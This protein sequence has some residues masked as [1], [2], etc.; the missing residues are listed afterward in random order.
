MKRS[1]ILFMLLLA[2]PVLAAAQN[3]NTQ[4][5]SNESDPPSNRSTAVRDRVVGPTRAANHAERQKSLGEDKTDPPSTSARELGG[6]AN[7][8][9]SAPQWGNTAVVIRSAPNERTMPVETATTDKPAVTEQTKKPPTKLVQKTSFTTGTPNATLLNRVGSPGSLAAPGPAP[10]VVY[11]VGVGDVLDIRLSNLP[12]KESTLFTVLKNGVLEYPLLSAPI[13]I[14]GMT[15]DEVARVL[16]NE[17]KVL[18][19]ARVSVSVRDYAS[20]AVV[21]SGLVDLPGTKIMRRE[22]MPLFAIVSG[23]LPRPEASL[24]SI[25]RGGASQTV[26]LSDEL[27]MSML[28]SPGDVIKVS[29]RN[30]ATQFV[31]VGGEV[32]SRGEKEFR[33]GMTL[34]QA[35]LTAG[36]VTRGGRVSVKIGRRNASGFLISSEYNLQSIEEGKTPDPLLDAGDRIEVARG[37]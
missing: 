20:H 23:A 6:T 19:N 2:I 35:I 16:E 22:A 29:G 5:R 11:H 10:T 34:T 1:I 17:I 18:K 27:G 32:A 30:S 8:S 33:N 7:Q 3:P 9:S 25:M 24:V 4:R 31:Y 14:C 37:L 36:G 26:S 13:S 12:T 28:V 21:I 15:T